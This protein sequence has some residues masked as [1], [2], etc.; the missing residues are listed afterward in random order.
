MKM[1]LGLSDVSPR[2]AVEAVEAIR[3]SEDRTTIL[4]FV[5]IHV[6]SGYEESP[7]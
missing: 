7:K 2:Q 1:M 3:A 4:G 6:L 5:T